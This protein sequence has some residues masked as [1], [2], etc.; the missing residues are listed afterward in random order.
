MT[1]QPAPSSPRSKGPSSDQRIVSVER[2][3]AAPPAAIFELLADPAAH[4]RFDGSD[5]VVAARGANPERLSLG[6]RFS[7]SMKFGLP[8]RMTNEVVEFEE[9][10]LIA[11]RHFGHHIWRYQ[12]EPVP[13]PTDGG[14]PD[15]NSTTLVTES[16][17][18]SD[19]RFPPLY[20]WLKY[21]E[22]HQQ[23]MARTLD[24]LAELVEGP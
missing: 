13:G 4:H 14:Q 22:R 11:W 8:Y 19:A 1:D 7:M 10:R 21:P 12:L 24:R 20:R 2:S 15:N 5:T 23:N 9:N 6:A 18:W 3:I 16:F 17:D